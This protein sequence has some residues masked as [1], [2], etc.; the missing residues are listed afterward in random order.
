MYNTYILENV[1]GKLYIGQ[2]NNL[3]NREFRHNSNM[4]PATKNK[5]PWKLIYNK[6]FFTRQDAV[7][8]ERYLKSLKSSKYIRE[9]IIGY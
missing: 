9:N 6:E 3:E 2:T 8:Y 1:Y 4:V 7:N 5:G